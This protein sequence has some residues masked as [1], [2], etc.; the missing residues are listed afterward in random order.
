[1]LDRADASQHPHLQNI[2]PCHSGPPDCHRYP[3]ELQLSAGANN[4]GLDTR[5]AI[6]A[7]TAGPSSGVSG[8]LTRWSVAR[9]PRVW[10]LPM[11]TTLRPERLLLSLPLY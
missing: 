9:E 10:P 11:T 1:M 3:R 2:A 7:S 4:S 6:A 8:G 5:A